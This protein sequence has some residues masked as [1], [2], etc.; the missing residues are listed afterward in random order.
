MLSS[1]LNDLII[2]LVYLKDTVLCV[3]FQV[4]FFSFQKFI[5]YGFFCQ[6]SYHLETRC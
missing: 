6:K 3:G 5:Q 1:K 4:D 2:C